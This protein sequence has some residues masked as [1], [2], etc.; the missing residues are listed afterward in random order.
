MLDGEGEDD[1]EGEGGTAPAVGE[2]GGPTSSQGTKGSQMRSTSARLICE[3]SATRH[4]AEAR[5]EQATMSYGARRGAPAGADQVVATPAHP[6]GP[7]LTARA[8][9]LP[10]I[11]YCGG[12]FRGDAVPVPLRSTGEGLP[13]GE[14]ER[15]ER[16]A[17][18]RERRAPRATS[19]R[20]D[21]A[22]TRIVTASSPSKGRP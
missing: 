22:T 9:R 15:H 10:H 4:I 1:L 5:Q 3:M 8:A 7:A 19:G 20:Q 21:R 13:P 18:Q 6:T 16:Q 14:A 2:Q 17:R 11:Q 12:R